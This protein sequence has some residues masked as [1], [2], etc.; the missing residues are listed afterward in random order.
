MSIA[1]HQKIIFQQKIFPL[2]CHQSKITHIWQPSSPT[3][4]QDQELESHPRGLTLE[5]FPSSLGA[6][7]VANL[8]TCPPGDFLPRLPRPWGP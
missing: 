7:P 2:S 1:K 4:Y 3:A 6:C 5:P 8:F